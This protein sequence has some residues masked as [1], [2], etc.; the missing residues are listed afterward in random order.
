M[1][2]LSN[3]TQII[4]IVIYFKFRESERTMNGSFV[5]EY[6]Y[7]T[8]KDTNIENLLNLLKLDA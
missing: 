6:S 3:D 8:K 2:V 4:I 1:T 5:Y 7:R